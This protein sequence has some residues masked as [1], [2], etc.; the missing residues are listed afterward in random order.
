MLYGADYFTEDEWIK[1]DF[2][3]HKGRYEWTNG[4]PLLLDEELMTFDD[5][6]DVLNINIK[7]NPVDQESP[8]ETVNSFPVFDDPIPQEEDEQVSPITQDGSEEGEIKSIIGPGE[9][10]AAEQELF[11]AE[12][13]EEEDEIVHEQDIAEDAW[14]VNSVQEDLTMNTSVKSKP[15]NGLT[16]GYTQA[17]LDEVKAFNAGLTKGMLHHVLHVITTNLS[18]TAGQ[19]KRPK[20]PQIADETSYPSPAW[21]EH[22]EDGMPTAAE[23]DARIS[24]WA[25]DVSEVE[26]IPELPIDRSASVPVPVTGPTQ[27]PGLGVVEQFI[28]T[29]GRKPVP[30]DIYQPNNPGWKGPNRTTET[31]SNSS[32]SRTASKPKAKSPSYFQGT[33]GA[34]YLARGAFQKTAGMHLEILPGDQIQYIKHVSGITHRGAN[35]RTKLQGHF[36]HTVFEPSNDVYLQQ[37]QVMYNMHGLGRGRADSSVS[38][39]LDKV[40]AMNAA[41]WD[42]ESVSSRPTTA[43]APPTAGVMGGLAGSRF[44]A[45]ADSDSS[46]SPSFT[47]ADIRQIIRE[48][49]REKPNIRVMANIPHSLLKHPVLVLNSSKFIRLP[50]LTKVLLRTSFQKRTLAGRST[51][52]L[53]GAIL[54]FECRFWKN[55]NDCRFTAE[56]CRDLHADVPPVHGEATNLRHGRPTWGSL[57]DALPPPPAPVP[58]V[59]TP[60]IDFKIF[61]RSKTCYYWATDGK[62]ANSAEDCRYLHEYT[63]AGVAPKPNGYNQHKKDFNWTKRK[64]TPRTEQDWKLNSNS[65]LHS[66]MPTSSLAQGQSWA[67][68]ATPESTPQTNEVSNDTGG[69]TTEEGWS[70]PKDQEALIAT[71]WGMEAIN[72]DT[73]NNPNAAIWGAVEGSSAWDTHGDVNETPQQKAMR[74]KQRIEAVGW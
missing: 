32:R 71:T 67:S 44:A 60:N 74:E 28:R 65:R 25:D 35:L 68:V 63:S 30:N 69:Y 27:P 6:E 7:N 37:Q 1:L 2:L 9:Q 19:K 18:M 62:C 42:R 22:G 64:E 24:S 55:K 26:P 33:P 43:G 48:E 40:E 10:I 20:Y 53:L 47:Q 56:E 34:V 46:R 61:S 17:Q 50:R 29:H 36:P 4:P 39:V 45:L 8:G 59:A 5:S 58:N 31:N 51:A 12:E 38:N 49:V 54:T 72:E 11:E 52:S 23:Q 14:K 41:E 70:I 73:L 66:T 3:I 15:A 16:A 21:S 57:A 13:E